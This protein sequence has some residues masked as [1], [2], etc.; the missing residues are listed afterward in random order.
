MVGLAIGRIGCF[1]NGC[2]YGKVTDLPWG[3][4]FPEAYPPGTQRHPTQIYESLLDLAVFYIL[5]KVIEKR[6]KFHGET[7]CY[8]IGLYSLVR[9]IVEFFRETF[10]SISPVMGMTVAQLTSIGLIVIITIIGIKI[11]T[12]QSCKVTSR[13]KNISETLKKNPVKE[14]PGIEDEEI[15]ICKNVKG[16]V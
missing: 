12:L 10:S 7:F 11:S 14:S 8:F 16:E 2:C 5:H 3:V 15:M 4:E 9:F 13:K 1:L 6:K